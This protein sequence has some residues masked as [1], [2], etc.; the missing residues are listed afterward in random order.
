MEYNLTRHRVFGTFS[1]NR[2]HLN[3]LQGGDESRQGESQSLMPQLKT[4]RL[5]LDPITAS[6]ADEW[7]TAVW[8]DPEVTRYLPPARAIPR[9]HVDRLLDKASE[10]WETHGFGI[11]AIR[12]QDTGNF[13]GH[14]GLVINQPPRVELIY[15]LARDHW[16]SGLGTEAAEAVV[17]YAGF[18]LGITELDALLFPDNAASGRVLEKLGF[19]HNGSEQR[20][21][22]DLLLYS[23]SANRPRVQAE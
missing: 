23:Y 15:A 12:E 10:E 6:D 21:G 20:F 17:S 2:S 19:F 5:V 13:I 1:G 14:C 16:G 9:D 4:N 7:W 11:W 3:I 22:L 8:S 18:A